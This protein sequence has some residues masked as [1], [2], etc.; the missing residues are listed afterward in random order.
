MAKQR[1][2]ST[3]IVFDA[4]LWDTPAWTS[5]YQNTGTMPK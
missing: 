1:M 2:W 3:V 4:T 5:R